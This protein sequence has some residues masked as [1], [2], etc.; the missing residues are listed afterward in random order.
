MNT[1]E[2]ITEMRSLTWARSNH[3]PGKVA[4]IAEAAAWATGDKWTDLPACWP[5]EISLL[6]QRI[7]DAADP[8]EYASIWTDER[9]ARMFAVEHG[10]DASRRRACQ[11]AEYA[12]LAYVGRR[13][14]CEASKCAPI[15]DQETA[16]KAQDALRHAADVYAT[17][18]AANAAAAYDADAAA[19]AAAIYADA[20]AHNCAALAVR[21]AATRQVANIAILDL[22]IGGTP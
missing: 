5:R 8:S 17:T 7:H 15:V 11:A 20:A 3:R 13:P 14:R 16:T 19:Y 10:L 6:A 9:L 2:I 1:A 21:A 22:W 18:A 4:C 12:R